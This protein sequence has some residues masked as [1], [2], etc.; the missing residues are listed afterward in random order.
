MGTI[1]IPEEERR[2]ESRRKEDCVN[3]DRLARIETLLLGGEGWLSY[4]KLV[5]KSLDETS[6]KID[7]TS[8]KLDGLADVQTTMQSN[9]AMMS[10]EISNLKRTAQSWGGGLGAIL[11]GVVS[12]LL[13]MFGVRPG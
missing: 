2:V 5:L 13:W 1:N 9:Q 11:G 10:T 7:E 3:E 8:R 12:A 6:K 4:Q